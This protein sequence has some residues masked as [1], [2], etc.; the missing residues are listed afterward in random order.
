MRRNPFKNYTPSARRRTL[1]TPRSFRQDHAEIRFHQNE[2][3]PGSLTGETGASYPVPS[4]FTPRYGAGYVLQN[5][6]EL[7]LVLSQ[8]VKKPKSPI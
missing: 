4:R 6:R 1:A 8:W 7:Y 5:N 2:K 3:F